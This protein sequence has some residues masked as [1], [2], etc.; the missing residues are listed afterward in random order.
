MLGEK[1]PTMPSALKEI[2]LKALQDNFS[3]LV[4]TKYEESHAYLQNESAKPERQQ[5]LLREMCMFIVLDIPKDR[6]IVFVSMRSKQLI[7]VAEGRD[8]LSQRM[9]LLVTNLR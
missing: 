1:M 7:S 4:P 3:N 9:S 5:D 2:G 6:N 8:H